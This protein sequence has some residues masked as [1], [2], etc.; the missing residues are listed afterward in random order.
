MDSALVFASLGLQ[1]N[2]QGEGGRGSV[3]GAGWGYVPPARS[4]SHLESSV[5]F[6]GAGGGNAAVQPPPQGKEGCAA[7]RSR[8]RR[9]ASRSCHPGGRGEERA[10]ELWGSAAAWTLRGGCR[11]RP[12]GICA[13]LPG[14]GSCPVGAEQG[15]TRGTL[16]QVLCDE[17]LSLTAAGLPAATSLQCSSCPMSTGW[18]FEDSFLALD[19]TQQGTD[20]PS[21]APGGQGRPQESGLDDKP[22]SETA[23]L[24]IVSP[25][26]C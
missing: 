16:K 26:L 24:R 14:F 12:G 21:A 2:C 25:D 7:P 13:S 5:P 6:G 1:V 22:G 19:V 8:S 23:G 20:S 3:A 11:Q 4:F 18:V 9:Q 10:A 17:L 15:Q